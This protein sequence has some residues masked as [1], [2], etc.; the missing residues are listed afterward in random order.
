MHRVKGLEFDA[1]IIVGVNDGVM[2]LAA[3][4]KEIDSDYARMA[5]EVKERSLLYVAATRAKHY[6]LITCSGEPSP[7]IG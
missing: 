2:P 4:A 7:F 1:M 3:A 5:L 6:V